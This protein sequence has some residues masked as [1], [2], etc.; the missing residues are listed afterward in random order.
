MTSWLACTFSYFFIWAALP[1]SSVSTTS[2]AWRSLF[3]LVKC[4]WSS[5]SWWFQNLALLS[6]GSTLDRCFFSWEWARF[7]SWAPKISTCWAIPHM[8][9][10]RT[11]AWILGCPT[12]SSGTSRDCFQGPSQYR[13]S[14]CVPLG[15]HGIK[16]PCLSSLLEVPIFCAMKNYSA[17]R[18]RMGLGWLRPAIDATLFY[19]RNRTQWQTF[20]PCWSL[21]GHSPPSQRNCGT[22]DLLQLRCFGDLGSILAYS[23]T[24]CTFWSCSWTSV[25]PEIYKSVSY[26]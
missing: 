3:I 9:P 22:E 2:R 17:V 8:R 11:P 19:N 7:P 13:V 24:G 18:C 6:W 4:L 26:Y 20:R 25:S 23:D 1:P 12:L 5:L 10:P 21:L 14:S 16:K 15:T